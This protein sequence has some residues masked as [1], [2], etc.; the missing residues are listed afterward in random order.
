[1]KGTPKGVNNCHFIQTKEL[2][3]ICS[4]ALLAVDYVL[5]IRTPCTASR[6]R[7]RRHRFG[8]P[9]LHRCG[10]EAYYL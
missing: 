6:G 2:V 8:C 3:S 1:M 10:P 7:G 4:L 9:S 5:L